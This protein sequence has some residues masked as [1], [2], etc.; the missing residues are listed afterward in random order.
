[1]TGTPA[2]GIAAPANPPG[3]YTEHRY[4]DECARCGHP[5]RWV[6][7]SPVWRHLDTLTG[8]CATT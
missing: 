5:V 2:P 6:S 8:E 3:Q 1:M 7:T 4:N